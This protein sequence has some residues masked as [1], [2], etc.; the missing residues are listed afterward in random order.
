MRFF[1]ATLLSALLFGP[2]VG[3]ASD[4]VPMSVAELTRRADLVVLGK[5]EGKEIKRDAQQRIFTEV[6]LAVQ[7]VWKGDPKKPLLTVVQ[8]GG[9]LGGHKAVVDG[10]VSYE[11]GEQV[12]GFFVWNERGEAVTLSMSQGKFHV[13][14]NPDGDPEVANPFMGRDEKRAITAA[15]SGGSPKLTLDSLKFQVKEAK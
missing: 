6:R 7:E 1:Q 14:Q 15:A 4:A 2:G 10:Q 5:V 13:T 3:V 12:V 8:G 9:I 11:P